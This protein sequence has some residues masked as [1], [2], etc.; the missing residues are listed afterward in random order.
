MSIYDELQAILNEHA[1]Y[2]KD[3]W[4]LRVLYQQ[5]EEIV[6]ICDEPTDNGSKVER[7]RAIAKDAAGL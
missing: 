4:D 3:R 5:M 1:R 6:E 7:I 2:E